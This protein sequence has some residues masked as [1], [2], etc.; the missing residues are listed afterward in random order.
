MLSLFSVLETLA[1]VIQNAALFRESWFQLCYPAGA[2]VLGTY[3]AI[4]SGVIVCI[5]S[6]LSLSLID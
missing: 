6:L 5:V 4:Y 1:A 3:M 2:L